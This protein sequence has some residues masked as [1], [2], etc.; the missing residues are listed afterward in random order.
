MSD[1][2]FLKKN[3]EQSIM[4]RDHYEQKLIEQ[5]GENSEQYNSFLYGEVAKWTLAKHWVKVKEMY[6]KLEKLLENNS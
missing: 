2:Y 6:N 5:F 4:I 1:R 3:Y